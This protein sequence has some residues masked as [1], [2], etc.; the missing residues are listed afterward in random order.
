MDHAASYESNKLPT[1]LLCIWSR[2]QKSVRVKQS[3]DRG[4][5]NQVARRR[6]EPID[7]HRLP[8]YQP[9]AA[10]RY[11]PHL[12]DQRLARL[13]NQPIPAHELVIEST[14]SEMVS[15]DTG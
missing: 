12:Y 14:R 9:R 11:C 5:M 6:I 7:R 2:H 13:P 3:L 10:S 8:L 4:Q 15:R 1:D